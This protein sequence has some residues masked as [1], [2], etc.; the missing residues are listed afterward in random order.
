MSVLVLGATGLIGNRL[1]RTLSTDL[2]VFGTTRQTSFINPKFSSLLKESNWLF[3]VSP[4]QLFELEGKIQKIKPNTIVN[5]LGVTKSKDGVVN[6]QESILVNSL[7]PHQL[8]AMCSESNIRLIHLSTDCVFS[9]AKGNYNEADIADPVDIYG[10]TKNLGELINEYD[11][12]I[13]TSFVGR[14]ISKFANLFEWAIKN[15]NTRIR[16]YARAIYSGLTTLALSK[17]IKIIIL[18]QPD[19]SGLWH[20]SSEPISKFEL[21]SRLNWELSLNLEIELD[22]TFICDRSLNSE[23]FRKRTQIEIP[24]WSEMLTDFRK[25]QSWYQNQINSELSGACES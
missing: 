9:G 23:L 10:K 20:I 7:F 11:L 21:L 25:D 4:K 2:E 15:R 6:L 14:E 18:E 17:I 13:R 24:N 16:C 8:S 22:E 3:N 19:L 5:C 1:V 12:T